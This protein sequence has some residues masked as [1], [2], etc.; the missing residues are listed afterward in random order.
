M[1][2]TCDMA[3]ATNGTKAVL[4]TRALAL[5]SNSSIQ[6][7]GF[8]AI[9]GT[10]APR[11]S[12]IRHRPMR[13]RPMPHTSGWQYHGNFP[14]SWA[15]V[16]HHVHAPITLTPS[17]GLTATPVI[18]EMP[19]AMPT[20]GRRTSF[21]PRALDAA[22]VAAFSGSAEG[23]SCATSGLQKSK[24]RQRMKRE[25]MAGRAPM[26][27]NSARAHHASEFTRQFHFFGKI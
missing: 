3:M 12:F 2:S 13:P 11:M 1:R 7:S 24:T 21:T 9:A 6:S 23:S 20:P 27:V 16:F 10:I 22:V 18:S 25:F 5:S 8:F 15:S 4:A 14:R 19:S 26:A 17:S